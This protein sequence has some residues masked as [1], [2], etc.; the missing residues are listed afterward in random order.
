[1]IKRGFTL[2][3]VLITLSIIGVVAALTMPALLQNVGGAKIGP[4]LAKFVNTFESAAQSMMV[5]EE[6]NIISD[7][8]EFDK[9]SRSRFRK[10][11][12]MSLL[13]RSDINIDLKLPDGK[14]VQSFKGNAANVYRLK[15][16]PIVIFQGESEALGSNTALDCEWTDTW[17]E[18]YKGCIGTAIVV[19]NGVKGEHFIGRD[20]FGFMIDDSGVLVP[21]GSSVHREIAS[22]DP[23]ADNSS[24]VAKC[25]RTTYKNAAELFACT[26]AVAD[27]N[28]KTPW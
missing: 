23:E 9:N 28:W 7:K 20:V 10:Y 25:N 1:M 22:G 18:P 27:N 11:Y 24:K 5:Q 19:L 13:G 14:L 26:G 12:P 3:E 21:Y 15:D 8:K 4:S 6:M 2:A 16:G 17:L